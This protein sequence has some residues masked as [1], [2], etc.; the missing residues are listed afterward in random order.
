MPDLALVMPM[1]GRGSRFAREGLLEPKPLIPLHGMPFFWWAVESVRRQVPLREMVF[2]VLEEHCEAFDIE[3]RIHALYP[4]AT[5]HAIPDVTSGAAETALVGLQALRTGGPVAVND[6]DH[7]F[8]SP[9]IQAL[10]P[11]LGAAL[12]GALMCFRSDNPAYSYAQVDETGQRVLRTVEKQVVSPWAIGG[13]YF[14]GDAERFSRLYADYVASCPYQELFMSGI[15]NLM[16]ER[17]GAV[18]K[19]D[20]AVHCSFGT[21]EELQQVTPVRFAPFEGW[22]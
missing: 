20:S 3:A 8:V 19:V 6:C 12:D 15:F 1:A 22:R 7:A 21:P 9:A 17:G 11:K 14:L 16:I 13:C 5:V 18:G 10:V 2:V 4:D